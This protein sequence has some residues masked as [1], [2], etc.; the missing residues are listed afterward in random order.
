M[1]HLAVIGV[2]GLKR[3]KS[4]F[5]QIAH[6]VGNFKNIAK[7]VAVRHQHLNG[8]HLLDNN[9]FLGSVITTGKGTGCMYGGL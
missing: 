1:A 2:C 5:K 4:Y 3:K 6:V 7:T 9:L 8:Y